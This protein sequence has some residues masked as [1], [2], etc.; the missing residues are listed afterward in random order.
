MFIEAFEPFLSWNHPKEYVKHWIRM[1]TTCCTS[2]KVTYKLMH[3]IFLVQV[4]TQWLYI[5]TKPLPFEP[6]CHRMYSRFYRISNPS[7]ND[8][9]WRA[10]TNACNMT[11][12]RRQRKFPADCF[13][14]K[15]PWIWSCKLNIHLRRQSS[16]QA[17][18][19]N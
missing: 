15:C 11:I 4:K 9:T 8:R 3:S 17:Y 14:T 12:A 5:I 18:K 10:R 19:K 2:F 13:L 16:L 1:D 7:S 6:F